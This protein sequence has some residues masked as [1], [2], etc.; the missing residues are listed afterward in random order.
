MQERADRN[1]FVKKPGNLWSNME[2]D[3][4]SPKTYCKNVMTLGDAAYADLKQLCVVLMNCGAGAQAFFMERGGYTCDKLMNDEPCFDANQYRVEEYNADMILPLLEK[5]ASK[6]GEF[7]YDRDY[8]RGF[9]PGA[10]LAGTLSLN[11]KINTK[12]EDYE[13]T[14]APVSSPTT[15]RR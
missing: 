12:V 8:L 15:S 11:L 9:N 4:Y 5:D 10:T 3:K 7:V 14:G 13:S 6:H 2:K 1:N